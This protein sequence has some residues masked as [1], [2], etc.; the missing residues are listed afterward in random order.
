MNREETAR[1]LIEVYPFNLF[2]E[3]FSIK[4]YS[5]DIVKILECTPG[6]LMAV[7]SEL[8]ERERAVI[9]ARFADGLTLQVIGET[10]TGTT[11]ERV[12]QILAAATRKL[13]YPSR[14]RQYHFATQH[15]EAESQRKSDKIAELT[16]RMLTL[17]R[18]NNDLKKGIIQQENQEREP[19]YDLEVEDMDL[20]V[21]S[22]NCLKRAGCNTVGDIIERFTP[23]GKDETFYSMLMR[24]RNL[25]RRSLEEVIQKLIDLHLLTT[26]DLL[27]G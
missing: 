21:R 17:A 3:I 26:D 27:C 20:S 22:Y 14:M 10:I 11:K 2:A 19:V 25:G 8:T 1:K 13:R 9:E 7:L 5:A 12:H 24:V 16:E 15:F 4:S 18:E 23:T 6:R